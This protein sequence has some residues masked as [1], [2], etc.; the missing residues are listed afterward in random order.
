MFTSLR[1]NFA[2]NIAVRIVLITIITAACTYVLLTKKMLFAPLVM[3]LLIAGL[4]INL[5]RYIRNTTKYL[6]HLLSSL[7]ENAYSDAL[8][9]QNITSETAGLGTIL[10]E[11]SQEFSR[12]SLER[13]L[14]FQYLQTIIENINVGILIFEP[15][16]ALQLAN[17]YAKNV[18]HAA[19]IRELN[20]L[21]A[22]DEKLYHAL[23]GM[24]AGD[25]QV[26]RLYF[27]DQPVQLSIQLKE[28]VQR[29][30]TLRIFL[31]QNIS[32][33]LD[34][35]EMEAWQK[36][37]QVLTHEIMNSVTPI[38]SLTDAIHGII[39]SEGHPKKLDEL[40]DDNLQDIQHSIT[41]ISSRSKSLMKFVN[42]YKEFSKT[43]EVKPELVD[44]VQL[45]QKVIDLFGAD[46]QTNRI[47]LHF[48][49]QRKVMEAKADRVLLEQVIINLLKNAIEA[50]SHDGEGTI[51]LQ[52][53]RNAKLH[54]SLS[55]NGPGIPPE[56]LEKI[57][58]PFFTTKQKG[59]GI[60]LSL[61]RQ[62]LR[63]HN[64]NLWVSS[65]IGEGSVFTI[66]L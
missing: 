10:H 14:H 19:H 13:E 7:K 60:G 54:I 18:L 50:V 42:A 47:K 51:S 6:S 1:Q 39:T 21:K 48:L 34:A 8:S 38:S 3:L 55:D 52:I 12:V 63:L 27:R 25:R 17:S 41:T 20:H 44:V 33:E 15:N 5:F 62:I 56:I 16:G 4:S 35:K 9:A 22:V 53:R 66:E 26:L 2:F 57:F 65:T 31:M 30:L 29:N 28:I 24:S 58:I 37:T 59:S 40:D 49:P 11:V 43:P 61:S 32:A 23:S 46:L 64:G 36:L 45:T